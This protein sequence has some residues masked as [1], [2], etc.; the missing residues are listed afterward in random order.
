MHLRTIELGGFSFG[1]L[2]GCWQYKPR[3]LLHG[4]QHQ[5]CETLVSCTRV[6]GVFGW[7]VIEI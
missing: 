4:H 5:N 6:V 7:R 1:G 3:L 2:N